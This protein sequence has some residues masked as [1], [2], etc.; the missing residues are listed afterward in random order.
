MEG[1]EIV[2]GSEYSFCSEKTAEGGTL[3]RH[4]K[5]NYNR[6]PRVKNCLG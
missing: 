4:E 6:E 1:V 5:A 2:S 3:H